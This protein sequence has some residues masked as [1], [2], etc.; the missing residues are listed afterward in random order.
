MQAGEEEEQA[1]IGRVRLPPQHL[2]QPRGK[3]LWAG[4]GAGGRGQGE[5]QGREAVVGAVRGEA[6]PWGLCHKPLQLQEYFLAMH[7]ANF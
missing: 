1:G 6:L 5:G 7:S 2:A 3:M 4:G